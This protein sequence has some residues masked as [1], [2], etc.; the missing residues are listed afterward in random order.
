[1]S[2]SRSVSHSTIKDVAAQAGVSKATV[3]RVINQTGPVATET[4][5]R[6]WA[7]IA[8]LDFTPSTAARGLA[9]R[10]TNTIGMIL[11]NIG[12]YFLAALFK[13]LA[14]SAD[15]YG[16]TLLMYSTQTRHVRKNR[17]DLTLPVGEH[18]TD[19]LIVFTD[20]L[21]PAEIIRLHKRGFPMVLLH[22]SPPEGVNIPCIGFENKKGAREMVE[23][24]IAVHHYQRIAFLAGFPGD[25]DSH[26]RELG[27]REAL[28]AHG[29]PFDPALVGVGGFNEGI[30]KS[31]VEQWLK[32]ELK[33]DAIFAADD[34]SAIGAMSALEQAGKRI[35]QDVAIVGFDDIELSRYLTPP[36]TTVRAPIEQVGRVAVEQ[37][38]HLIQTEQAEPLVL[39]PT[40]LV[41]RNSCGCL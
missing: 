18:N 31:T 1:M 2:N 35:P 34:E 20:A 7:A 25:E 22:R 4:A 40:T 28:A 9:M 12:N 23:H 41:V 19:G 8:E 14:R 29:I 21:D 17:V 26:W 11:P 38:L 24:L 33:F 27:Y 5:E 6:V 16:Y 15:E 10:K 3:S 32:Q 36:L 30:A 37:L 13:G 39:L